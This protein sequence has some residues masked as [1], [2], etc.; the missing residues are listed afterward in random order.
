[1]KKHY[2]NIPYRV[3]LQKHDAKAAGFGAFRR[4]W[5]EYLSVHQWRIGLCMCIMAVCSFSPFITAFYARIVVDDVLQVRMTEGDPSGTSATGRDVSTVS[6]NDRLIA[7]ARAPKAGTGRR[8]ES[9]SLP[10]PREPAASRR[11]FGMGL[12]WISTVVLINLLNR[13]LQ[14]ARIRTEC[15]L[16]GSLRDAL[17]RKILELS[18]AYHKLQTPGRLL[19]RITSDVEQVQ[20][21]IMHLLLGISRSLSMVVV[22]FV[23]V[24]VV[25]WR[26]I[27]VLAVALPLCSYLYIRYR[28]IIVQYNR[29]LRQTNASLYGYVSQKFDAVKA[30][31]A[32]GRESY[33]GLHFHRLVS[34][35]FRDAYGQQLYSSR[36]WAQFEIIAGLCTGGVLVLGARLVMDGTMSVG[37][38]V[39]LYSSVASLFGPIIQLSHLSI[40]YQNMLV[41]IQRLTAVLDE[42]VEIQES[43]DA[44]DFP[45]PMKHGIV[46]DHVGFRY[47]VEPDEEQEPI[48][49]SINFE[50]PVG[51]WLCI[52][53]PSGSGKSSLLYLLTRLYEPTSGA[54]YF[55]GL[56]I[57]RLKMLSLRRQLGFVPQEAQIMSGT[58][59]DNIAY[60]YSDAQPS[61]IMA[62]AKAAQLHDFIMTM[63]V[64]YETL[65]GEK[66]ISLS[67]GQRQRLSLARALLTNPDVLVLDDCTSAL[68]AAT[69]RRIQDTLAEIMIGKTAIIVS[70]RVSMAR[71]CHRIATIE[72][73]R[74]TEM[75]THDELLK[76]DG[77]YSRLYAQQTE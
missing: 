43:P 50:V 19:S 22:G 12:L 29:E 60:G 17:H 55:D 40:V 68:D 57:S 33:E 32:Y 3:P 72:A 65:I 63:P 54:I 20:H 2:R 24:L 71:R 21:Q 49:D 28:S 66:G 64:C 14:F 39:F 42:S 61:E 7:G 37:R 25:E 31:Q 44:V 73:G 38:M 23:I 51:S 4:I 36:M 48:L 74:I 18:L 59:R 41:V 58:I 13:V 34:C 8:L 75:G 11:L 52:M 47:G 30:V 76:A 35:F 69:E 1:M 62:A 67:G 16:T 26:L 5:R 9:G 77:F 53:G 46:V 70:Q 10:V 45:S 27:P 6:A 15:S 56:P